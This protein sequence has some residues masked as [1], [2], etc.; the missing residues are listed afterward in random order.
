MEI[1]ILDCKMEIKDLEWN[2]R[3]GYDVAKATAETPF[4]IA[5]IDAYFDNKSTPDGSTWENIDFEYVCYILPESLST[6]SL[7]HGKFKGPDCLKNAQVYIQQYI[8]AR[9]KELIREWTV[10]L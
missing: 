8:E 10:S 9:I 4:G 6:G 1:K 7:Y 5:Y 2:F 3:Y